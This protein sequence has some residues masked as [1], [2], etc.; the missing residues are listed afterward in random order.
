MQVFVDRYNKFR[1]D[2]NKSFIKFS[3]AFGNLPDNLNNW[4]FFKSGDWTPEDQKK[5]IRQF[6]TAQIKKLENEKTAFEN[7][8]IKPLGE[9]IN[10]LERSI[11]NSEDNFKQDVPI[12]FEFTN[13]DAELKFST[14]VT[15]PPPQTTP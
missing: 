6:D 4:F 2:K 13:P 3:E 14:T 8:Q 12:T 5:F 10:S 1:A 7:N 11:K 15:L 9:E